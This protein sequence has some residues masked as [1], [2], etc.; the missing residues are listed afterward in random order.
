MVMPTSVTHQGHTPGAR[1]PSQ[2]AGP[3]W[4]RRTPSGVYGGGQKPLRLELPMRD[5]ET[6]DLV[7]KQESDYRRQGKQELRA[8]HD[9]H[10]C[11]RCVRQHRSHSETEM[12]TVGRILKEQPSLHCP[13]DNPPRRQEISA[14]VESPSRPGT[15]AAD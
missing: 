6:Y 7:R 13:D 15:Q 3:A 12:P 14:A 2:I 4:V 10:D 1:L 9:K 8:D 5:A 11:E